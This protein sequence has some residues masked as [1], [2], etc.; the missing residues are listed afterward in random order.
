MFISPSPF[1]ASAFSFRVCL[2]PGYF[3][4]YLNGYDGS[5]I[6][7]GWNEWYGQLKNSRYYNYTVNNNGRLLYKGGN[8]ERD[9]STNVYTD[10]AARFFRRT[11]ARDYRKPIMMTVSYAAPHGSEDPAPQHSQLFPDAK[12]PR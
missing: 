9:Y 6:P 4:K 1:L 5:Y 2:L 10:A 12:A 11:K 8:Y 3:G 7:P